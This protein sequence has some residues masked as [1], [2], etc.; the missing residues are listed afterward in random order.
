MSYK[1]FNYKI[2]GRLSQKALQIAVRNKKQ[3]KT[4]IPTEKQHSPALAGTGQGGFSWLLWQPFGA[5]CNGL[6]VLAS[7]ATRAALA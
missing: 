1:G 7:C 2:I 4:Q 6:L 3:S 5:G